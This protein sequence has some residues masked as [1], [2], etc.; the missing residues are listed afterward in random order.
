M[1]IKTILSLGALAATGVAYFGNGKFSKYQQVIKQLTFK[2]KNARN[3]SF[4]GGNVQLKVDVEMINP[5]PTAIDVPGK[6]ITIQNIHFFSLQ[7]NN[8]G[9]ATPNLSEISLPANGTRLVTNIPV[10]IPLS[11]IG[12]NI[13]EIISILSD[14][15]RLKI[16]A[17]IQ[18]FGKQF[19]INA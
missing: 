10:T 12:N 9:T 13:T 18:A 19:T 7:G 5:T 4:S 1:K 14:T 11:A 16:T 8:L 3:I 15:S 6:L 17:D 2:L